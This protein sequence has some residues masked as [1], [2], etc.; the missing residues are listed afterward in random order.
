[1]ALQYFIAGVGTISLIQYQSIK[2]YQEKNERDI[3]TLLK[4]HRT[5]VN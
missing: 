4:E 3:N 2:R 1:M 5:V